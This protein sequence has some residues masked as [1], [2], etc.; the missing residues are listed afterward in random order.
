VLVYNEREVKAI[1][2]DMN[3]SFLKLAIHRYNIGLLL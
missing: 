1:L 3:G 2:Q